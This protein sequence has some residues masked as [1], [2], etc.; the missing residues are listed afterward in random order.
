[1]E[2]HIF[3]NAVSKEG[4]INDSFISVKYVNKCDW[5]LILQNCVYYISVYLIYSVCVR[6]IVFFKYTRHIKY[7]IL[8]VLLLYEL[9]VL[10]TFFC[11]PSESTVV[12][13]AEIQKDI[14][15]NDPSILCRDILF[16][17]YHDVRN[18]GCRSKRHTVIHSNVWSETFPLAH[19]P[20]AMLELFGIK[21]KN[22]L[23]DVMFETEKM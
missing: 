13:T 17:S 7:L 19:S 14:K 3:Q 9:S 4:K 16:K 2:S 20:L 15:S 21:A 23:E 8:G 1:M 12:L 5:N 10:W 11:G 18:V 22:E 6:Y